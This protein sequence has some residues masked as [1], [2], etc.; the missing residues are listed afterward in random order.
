MKVTIEGDLE[1][2]SDALGRPKL[3][4]RRGEGYISR[5]NRIIAEQFELVSR[6]FK[7]VRD[8]PN[9]K[10]LAD[11]LLAALRDIS[12]RTATV[13]ETAQQVIAERS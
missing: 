3:R 13:I 10:L 2:V 8:D 1:Q 9:E 12:K 4:A 5:E 11:M 7:L 6:A